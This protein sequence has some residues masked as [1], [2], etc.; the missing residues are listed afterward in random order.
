M[1]LQGMVTMA[2]VLALAACGSSDHADDGK[3]D[4]KAVAAQGTACQ[5]ADARLPGTGLCASDASKIMPQDNVGREKAPEGCIWV[6]N[7]V[8]LAG[9]DYLLYRGLQCDENRTQLEYAPG[10]P[11]AELRLTKSAYGPMAEEAYIP[12][13]LRAFQGVPAEGTPADAVTAIVRSTI[14]DPAEARTCSARKADIESWPSDALVVDLPTAE[15][16]K[17]PLDEI[18]SAC[19]PYGLDQGSQRYWRVAQGYAWFFDLGQDQPEIDPGSL[20]VIS[21][22]DNGQYQVR[23]QPTR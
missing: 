17:M 15:T 3:A 1:K 8:G 21:K 20:T 5:D 11:F 18:R 4:E 13:K 10:T 12:V 2:L 9:S 23:P 14:T 6:I 7:E 19:G 22:A 16:A